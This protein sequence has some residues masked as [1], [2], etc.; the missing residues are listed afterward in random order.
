MANSDP[1]GAR[2]SCRVKRGCD[3]LILLFK[4]KIK[5][6][7]PRFTRQ[8]LQKFRGSEVQRFRSYGFMLFP[9][10]GIASNL[11]SEACSRRGPPGLTQKIGPRSDDLLILPLK[12]AMALEMLIDLRRWHFLQ[13]DQQIMGQ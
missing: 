6:S 11:W 2:R 4:N 5:R 10:F 8:L 1:V 9:T 12:P 13:A 7:Q 3:L